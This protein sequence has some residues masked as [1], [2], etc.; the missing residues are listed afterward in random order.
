MSYN[1]RM[2]QLATYPIAELAQKKF[3]LVRAGKTIYD[4]GAGDPV[5]PTPKNIREALVKNLPEVSQYPTTKGLPELRASISGY[6]SRRFGVAVDAA[7]EI[8]PTSGSK[9]AIYN[10]PFMF[11]HPDCKKDTVI[12]PAP[13]YF[14]FER[15]AIMAG[16]TYH[17]YELTPENDYLLE[18]SAVPEAILHQ[19]AVAWL[20]YPHNP[21]GI[22]CDLDYFKRQV[23]TAAKY[24]IVLCSDECYV[25]LYFGAAPPPSLL[26]VTNERVLVFHSCSKRSGMTGYRSGFVAGDPELIEHF[27]GFRNTV[28][29]AT[30]DLIQLAALESW[31]DDQHVA[32][33]R[34]VFAE[35]RSLTEAFCKDLGLTITPNEATFYYWI[36][37]P[38]GM[39]GRAYAEKLLD[40][41]IVVSAGEFFAPH[42]SRF[43][44]IALG[45]LLANLEK[46]FDI[47]SLA[48]K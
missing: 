21:T 46:A 37:A 31:D 26:E 13:G 22:S 42:C 9:E 44:R 18:L 41:G 11:L 5:D 45:P 28:G 2:L 25:D 40:H 36:E 6:L 17:G 10:L 29:T 19:T 7:S 33:R 3:D 35:K 48:V 23:E 8:L 14:I 34:Q 30:P 43:F 4:F 24:D 16:G 47:W 1:P 39:T 15:G 12:G 38:G 32:K 27:R 20:N